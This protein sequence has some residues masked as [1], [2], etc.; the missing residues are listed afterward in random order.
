MNK[1]ILSNDLIGNIGNCKINSETFSVSN[2]QLR[3]VAVNSCNGE[4]I[5]DTGAYLDMPLL[6]FISF[7]IFGF[8]LFYSAI[9]NT[10][11]Y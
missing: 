3:S 11:D 10:L 5:S 1:V 6:I 8:I 2:F 7:V 9:K 4:I